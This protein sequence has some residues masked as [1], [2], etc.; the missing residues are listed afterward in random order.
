M[1]VSNDVRH[2][3]RVLTS[4]L[5]LADAGLAVTILGI[6]STGR[7]EE[8]LLGDVAVIR[9]PVPSTVRASVAERRQRRICEGHQR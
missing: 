9:I 1:V 5:A 4:A 8:S 7:R 2:D 3:S 6:S